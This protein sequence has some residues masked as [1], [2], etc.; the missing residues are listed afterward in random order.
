MRIYKL[1]IYFFIRS[2]YLTLP[3]IFADMP[4]VS[5]KVALLVVTLEPLLSKTIIFINFQADYLE[6]ITP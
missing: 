4:K 5:P 1:S 2:I 6:N 3:V